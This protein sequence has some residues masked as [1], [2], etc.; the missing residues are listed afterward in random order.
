MTDKKDEMYQKVVSAFSTIEDVVVQAEKGLDAKDEKMAE[1]SD[2]AT[3][4]LEALVRLRIV[5]KKYQQ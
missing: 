2:Y 1:V 4:V 3:A 5:V